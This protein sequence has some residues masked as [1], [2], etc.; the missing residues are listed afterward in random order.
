M[1]NPSLV[2]YF[3]SKPLVVMTPLQC[4]RVPLA[5]RWSFHVCPLKVN[6]C[7]VYCTP[8]NSFKKSSK[9]KKQQKSPLQTSAKGFLTPPNFTTMIVL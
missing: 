3:H 4:G 5:D 1:T 7:S 2:S 8:I 6:L 9:K